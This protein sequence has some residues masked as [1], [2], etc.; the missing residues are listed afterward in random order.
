L[1]VGCSGLLIA[2]SQRVRGQHISPV[3]LAQQSGELEKANRLNQQVYQLYQ[4]WYLWG[5]SPT[6][7]IYKTLRLLLGVALTLDLRRVRRKLMHDT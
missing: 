4:R 1:R 5:Q 2:T 7:Q 3:L 6:R